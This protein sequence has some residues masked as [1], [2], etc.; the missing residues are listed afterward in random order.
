MSL[1]ERE[2]GSKLPFTLFLDGSE[3]ILCDCV[4]LGKIAK[5]FAHL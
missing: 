3:L 2:C 1:I 5:W 4:L